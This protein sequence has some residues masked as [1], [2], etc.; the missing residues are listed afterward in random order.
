M[1][2]KKA[3]VNRGLGPKL[4]PTD[5]YTQQRVWST[6][7]PEGSSP[8]PYDDN[9]RYEKIEDGVYHDLETNETVF[10]LN[11]E[12]QQQF[13]PIAQ[14]IRLGQEERRSAKDRWGLFKAEA[15][16]TLGVASSIPDF[17]EDSDPERYEELQILAATLGSPW[18]MLTLGIIAKYR[19]QFQDAESWWSKAHDAGAER[20]A[21]NNAGMWESQG[22]LDKAMAWLIKGSEAGHED[23]IKKLISFA[24]THGHEELLET[25]TR[26]LTEHEELKATAQQEKLERLEAEAKALNAEIHRE[27]PDSLVRLGRIN[28]FDFGKQKKA[29]AIF[30]KAAELGS[31]DAM[32]MLGYI[33]EWDDEVPGDAIRWYSAGAEAGNP[34]S[35][36]S[37]A[38][39][40]V[41]SGD[42]AEGRAWL[43]KAGSAGDIDAVEE[44]AEMAFIEG[45]QEGATR[46]IAQAA[47]LRKIKRSE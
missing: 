32:D 26:R 18:A 29:R 2:S 35:Q 14:R 39:L 24:T 46:L 42:L 47:D 20:G 19:D 15:L 9:D 44:L 6:V 33:A 34:A 11:A 37:L 12:E 4:P 43:E 10:V 31:G 30:E 16:L 41:K 40:L 13:A 8:H 1:E 21:L 28:Y 38:R 22:D 5:R 3:T 17:L 27:N 23:A 36:T 7:K 45:D 25:W